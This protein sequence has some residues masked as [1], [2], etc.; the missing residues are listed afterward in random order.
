[1]DTH[2]KKSP[3]STRGTKPC[4]GEQPGE[5]KEPG[6]EGRGLERKGRA[7]LACLLVVS[8]ALFGFFYEQGLLLL[9]KT[10]KAHILGTEWPLVMTDE[11]GLG[12]GKTC[13]CLSSRTIFSGRSEFGTACPVGCGS[14]GKTSNAAGGRPSPRDWAAVGSAGRELWPVGHCPK[15]AESCGRSGTARSRPWGEVVLATKCP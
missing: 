8:A 12:S 3:E 5:R 14:V 11:A 7:D 13:V 1:M 4:P 2:P 6:E 10:T 9:I 15:R